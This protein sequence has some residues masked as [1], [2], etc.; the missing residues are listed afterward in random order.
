MQTS[1]IPL[2]IIGAALS[3]CGP[4]NAPT[5]SNDVQ[6]APPSPGQGFQYVIPDFMVAPGQDVQAC[7]FFAIP[8]SSGASIWVDEIVGAQNAHSHHLDVYRK[9][10]VTGLDGAPGD[11]VV[12]G[13][14][15]GPLS[16]WADW[17]LV[18]NTQGDQPINWKLPDGVGLRFQPGEVLMLQTH[19]LNASNKPLTGRVLV[20][21]HTPSTAPA[22]ELGTLFAAN[23]KIQICPGDSAKSFDAR[24]VF[25]SA[26]ATIIAA[27][28]HFH[29]RGRDFAMFTFD[30][31][32]NLGAQFYNSTH[33]DQ[34]LM[35]RDLN[36]SVPLNG[37]VDWKC[38][39]DYVCPESGRS[40]GDP[41]DN[42]CFDF[43]GNVDIQE[44]CNAF[45]YYW[46]ST[47]DITCS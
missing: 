12:N 6:L 46:P 40:C 16:N 2:I 14:C 39:Y 30:G 37:G 3:A 9:K 42:Y 26:N 20:N 11:V 33:W 22:N 29:S 7:Y 15:Y 41:K 19:Y 36:V 23:R 17:P 21:F 34:P 44:H 38:S 4:P 43:G 24:C 1:R 25:H 28:G 10:T 18:I 32:G 13:A 47:K 31:Q 45:V 8:G 5:K 35:A 27:N